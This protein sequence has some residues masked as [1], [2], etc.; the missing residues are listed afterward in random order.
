MALFR[1]SITSLLA[2][3]SL[4]LTMAVLG[5][6]LALFLNSPK[7]SDPKSKMSTGPAPGFFLRHPFQPR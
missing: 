4:L 1:E 7:F 2:F 5:S 3:G 6:G